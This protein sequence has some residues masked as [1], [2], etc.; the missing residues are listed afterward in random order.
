MK[1]LKF[2]GGELGDTEYIEETIGLGDSH[3]ILMIMR[4]AFAETIGFDAGDMGRQMYLTESLG[5]GDGYTMILPHE[6]IEILGLGDILYQYN[7]TEILEQLGLGD[8]ISESMDIYVEI[9]ENIGFTDS[10]Y[11]YM[12]MNYQLRWRTR[13]KKF[14]YGYGATLYGD[15]TSYGDGD[16]IDELKE[17]KVKV[18]RL[19]DLAVLRTDTITI[20]NKQY[21]DGSAQY[22]Y[23]AAMNVSDNSYFEPNLRFEIYQVD[24]NDI[25]SPGKYLDITA[26]TEGGD[27]I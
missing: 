8:S 2:I 14:T 16:V 23:T 27:L 3:S 24:I 9:D 19:S 17:F 11:S 21:P 1:V 5:L 22:E 18:I 15:Q 7:Y 26:S 10:G 25:W 12:I 13:T 6:I 20:V 4:E